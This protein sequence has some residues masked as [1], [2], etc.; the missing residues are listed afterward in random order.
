MLP[1]RSLSPSVD[2]GSSDQLQ[3]PTELSLTKLSLMDGKSYDMLDDS[4]PL[5][6]SDDIPTSVPDQV[7]SPGG[8]QSQPSSLQPPLPPPA[9][10]GLLTDYSS[11][12]DQE[13]RL[14]LQLDLLSVADANL[15]TS[16]SPANANNAK[17]R[18]D[19]HDD[20]ISSKK[21]NQAKST[22]LTLKEQGKVLLALF[23]WP[24]TAHTPCFPFIQWYI[25]RPLIDST[26]KT[27]TWKWKSIIWRSWHPIGSA[28]SW[29]R[30]AIQNNYQLKNSLQRSCT[31][32]Q[33]YR[34]KIS[35]SILKRLHKNWKNIKRWYWSWIQQWTFYIGQTNLVQ[36][37]MACLKRNGL[38]IMQRWR[39]LLSI[40]KRMSVFSRW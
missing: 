19:K 27:L 35:R 25:L 21:E 34:T 16:I 33:L 10:H 14:E 7:K 11:L 40:E 17:D 29:K 24:S 13:S 37:N 5:Q 2:G 39:I 4:P 31:F 12:F 26:K 6:P 3:F 1:H 32:F 8:L 30:L 36:S 22:T 23:A 9:A 18:R 38:N 28:K 20:K 15:S